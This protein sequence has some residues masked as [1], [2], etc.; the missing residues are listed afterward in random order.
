MSA[1]KTVSKWGGVPLSLLLAFSLTPT[2]ALAGEPAPLEGE[3]PEGPAGVVTSAS[4]KTDPGYVDENDGHP[5]RVYESFD[6]VVDGIAYSV[7]EGGVEVSPWYWVW[8]PH[9]CDQGHTETVFCGSEYTNA[10]ISIPETVEYGGVARDVV[11][12]GNAAFAN[13]SGYTVEFPDSDKFTY[14]GDS[15]FCNTNPKMESVTIPASVT[16]IGDHSFALNT[17]PIAGEKSIDV[18]IPE[19]SKLQVIG[20]YA[21]A[22]NSAVKRLD[23]P[24]TLT[25]IGH[26]AFSKC[27]S[28]ASI[29][30]PASVKSVQTDTLDNYYNA[31]ANDGKGN[32][33]FEEDSI[34][35][36]QNGVFYDD[37]SLIRVLDWQENVVVPDG[38]EYIGE[39]AFNAYTT[40]TPNE[41]DTLKSIEFP[42]SLVSI[43]DW[44]FRSCKAL[45]SVVIPENVTELGTGAF[46]G[47]VSLR[48]ATI[49]GPIRKLDQT[50]NGCTS[51]ETVVV[52]ET[53]EV[54]GDSTFQGC[55]KL[56]SF[57]FSNIREIGDSAFLQTG[58]TSLRGADKLDQIE[59]K[60]FQNC[61][62]LETVVLP[63]AVQELPI[64]SFRGC[65]AL[66]LMVLP[67]TLKTLG[68][69][70]IR[71]SFTGGGSLVMLGATPPTITTPFG[72]AGTKPT[73]LTVY[74][75]AE[76][77]DAYKSTV[78]VGA[79]EDN[80][81]ALSLADVS[82]ALGAEGSSQTLALNATVP[83][84]MTLV[85]VSDN[86]Q[87]ATVSGETV[88]GVAEG[89]ANITAQLKVGDYVVLEDACT[90]TVVDGESPVLPSVEDPQTSFGESISIDESDKTAVTA[91]M[92]SVSAGQAMADA[93][94][95]ASQK[96]DGDET[97]KEELIEE[98]AK[99]LG[100]QG[101]ETVSL[102]T[103]AY[104]D[105]EA[106]ELRKN[107]DVQVESLTLDITPMV[108]VVA[109]TATNSAEV[110]LTEES[111]N[112]VVVKEAE[113]LSIDGPAK[114][115]VVL[116][117]S[118]AGE[119]VYVKHEPDQGGA[120]FYKSKAGDDGSVTFTTKDGF[121][122][123]AFSLK[124]G[125]VAEVGEIGYGSFQDAVDAVSSDGAIK[126]LKDTDLNAN[127][128]GSSRTVSIQNE[129]GSKITVVL[130]GM[131]I[132][133]EANGTAEY[134]YSRPSGGGGAVA[135][136]EYEVSIGEFP[137]GKISADVVSAEE[138]ETVTLSAVAEPGFEL[139]FVSVVGP[140]GQEVE[141]EANAD[142]TY[143]FDMPA[144]DV[145]V[146][147]AF[148][149][150]GGELCPSHAFSDVD[151]E[152]WY[153]A[154]IDWAVDNGVLH[155][156]GDTGLMAPD[157]VLTRAQMAT[158]LWNLD[159]NEAVAY[160]G[161]FS[162]VAEGDWFSGAVSWAVSEGVFFGYEGAGQFGPNDELTREQAAVVLMRWS[163]LR[164]E[165]VSVRAD[166]FAFPDA[167]SVS[168]WA[169]EAMSWAVAEGV[170][171]GVEVEP[172][173]RELQPL[174]TATRAQ[175]AAL[176]MNLSGK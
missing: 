158:I 163:A 142:G 91:V 1:R 155:G 124:N 69:S 72:S 48:S 68:S 116:P 140:D 59:R 148:E 143:S 115:S 138:G 11:G 70:S 165:D 145:E 50:F 139:A 32:V 160:D 62:A 120:L 53:V 105:I 30:I 42:E 94:A 103:Q 168:E 57:D 7:V 171:S 173:V 40:Q 28:L 113:E 136:P 112:A 89:T 147:A 21:F 164:G 156:I 133:I 162:D 101:G 153:H 146:K 95:A 49:N 61:T 64:S 5:K 107:G 14:I 170:L 45:E 137:N 100:L 3:G 84:G 41:M 82:M 98:G 74:Y 87:V 132:E 86:E 37:E 97:A 46:T 2:A 77:A 121:S 157:G 18:V 123:F 27:K 85:A 19:N 44:A 65:S 106:T 151:C 149:C 9:P 134:E 81:Y 54:I 150:D 88:T 127:V 167:A 122:P 8:Q 161:S 67:E 117:E 175:A 51:L 109:S 33:F 60:A 79:D 71:D 15:V 12:I 102:F 130:N 43:G 118:F 63:D 38:I 131:Q 172:G 73:G 154:A 93:A 52:P 22:N 129:T 24:D 35:K 125:A 16:H 104:L 23:F 76:A 13:A 141:L 66:K 144:F 39:D 56:A 83:D 96:L 135:A 29:T 152:Q 159:G 110:D 4:D 119:Q 176:M 166:L 126:V 114:V 55:A 34:F 26:L 128:S 108:R 31:E 25:T 47:C 78:L 111:G 80:G 6:F 92:A 90:V 75:P 169:S 20:D 36:I 17:D 174:G 58:I 99:H 10:T